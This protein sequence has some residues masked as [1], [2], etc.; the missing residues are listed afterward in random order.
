M[1]PPEIGHVDGVAG[2]EIPIGAR[3]LKLAIDLDALESQGLMA[4]ME[5]IP[6]RAPSLELHQIWLKQRAGSHPFTIDPMSLLQVTAALEQLDSEG[7]VAGRHAIYQAR[8][9]LLRAG[10]EHLGLRIARWEGMPL[11]SIGTALYIPDGKRYE[12]M[13]DRL[14]GE[15]ID[16]HAFEIYAA[17]GRLS[18]TLFR[19]FHMGHY[20]LEVYELFL[21]ALARV[22]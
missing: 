21:K 18:D 7:G 15:P 13:A 9:D 20:P 14:A 22:I 11:Q 10:Y 16:D 6:P 12:E 1:V 3:I 19:V 8:C 2:S 5:H 17:Q 4:E